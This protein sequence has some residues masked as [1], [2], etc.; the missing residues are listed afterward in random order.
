MGKTCLNCDTEIT[1]DNPSLKC[2]H[3]GEEGCRVCM[4]DGEGTPPEC[5]ECLM[6]ED[7]G[8]P[9]DFADLDEED[10]G[11]EDE[12]DFGDDDETPVPKGDFDED[13][14]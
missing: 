11:D 6:A 3:C 10:F 14:D 8:K 7:D 9:D 5:Y 12:E 2:V 4:S 13:D 1:K